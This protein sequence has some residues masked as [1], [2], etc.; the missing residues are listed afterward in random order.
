MI[1]G[2]TICK[3]CTTKFFVLIY[4]G[5]LLIV[6]FLINFLIVSQSVAADPYEGD[7]FENRTKSFKQQ[8]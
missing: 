2:H 1:T 3:N 7:Q 4:F 8:A 6:T 5:I